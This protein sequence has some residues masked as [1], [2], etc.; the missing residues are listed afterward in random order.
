MGVHQS[1]GVMEGRDSRDGDPKTVLLMPLNGDGQQVLMI[2]VLGTH[3]A[4]LNVAATGSP[5]DQ[6]ML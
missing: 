6:T 1:K 2:L 3:P 5:R 4:N